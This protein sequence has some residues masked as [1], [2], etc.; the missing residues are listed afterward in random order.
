MY[1]LLISLVIAA[2]V[3]GCATITRGT[4]SQVQIQSEPEGAQ[5]RTSLGYS[6]ITPCTITVNR[7]DEF[8][9]T[10]FMPGYEPQT[11]PVKT[12]VAGS[13]AAG[14]AGNIL[15]GGLIGMGA[16]AA[17]GAAL[18]H[19]PNPVFA[20]LVPIVAPRPP[21]P[22]LPARPRRDLVPREPRAAPT[23]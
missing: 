5:V 21:P 17:T 20:A 1:R 13:G 14:F 18:E 11:V 16:D 9:V 19:V 3:G 8:A 7:K 23:Q 10:F 22:P 2:S 6:C 4:T 12:Q 15:L